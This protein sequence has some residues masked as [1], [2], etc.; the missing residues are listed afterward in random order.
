LQPTLRHLPVVEFIPPEAFARHKKTAEAL[1][2]IHVASGPMVRSS[3][4][5]DE[6]TLARPARE[7]S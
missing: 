5:A 7:D 2:F 3:Y 1:G 4:H 6:F